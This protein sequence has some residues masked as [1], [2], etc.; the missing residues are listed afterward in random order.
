MRKILV[1]SSVVEFATGLALMADP[2]IVA[3]LLLGTVVSGPGIVVGRCFG[4][5]LLGLALASWPAGPVPGRRSERFAGMLIYNALIAVYLA[6]LGAG[7]RAN[8]VLLWPAAAL[9]CAVALALAWTG[10]AGRQAEI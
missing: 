3:R 1:F 5:A 10:R 6:A 9:H 8:G 4:I 2:S 7:G